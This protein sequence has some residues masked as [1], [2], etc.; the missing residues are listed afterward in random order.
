MKGVPFAGFGTLI[1]VNLLLFGVLS[2][3][4][5]ILSEYIGLIYEE[6]KKR[7]SFIVDETIN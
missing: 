7:P 3:M 4:I 1:S 6:V 5:G 2:F